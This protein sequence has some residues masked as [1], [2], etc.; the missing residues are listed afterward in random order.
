[1][2]DLCLDVGV[3]LYPE[4][5]Y[6]SSYEAYNCKDYGFYDENQ[7]AYPEKNKEE[8][9]SYGKKYVEKKIEG[10]YAVLTNQGECENGND[11]DFDDG[12]VEGFTYEK[13]TSFILSPK[14]TKNL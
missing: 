9:I 4:D 1:M 14:L 5:P 10:T 12:C 11:D 2:I 8:A 13:K 6:F 7:I 3:L